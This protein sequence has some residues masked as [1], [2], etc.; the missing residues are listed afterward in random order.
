MTASIRFIVLHPDLFAV[1]GTPV[2]VRFSFHIGWRKSFIKK[3]APNLIQN[4]G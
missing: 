4:G 3:C 2:L 1:T